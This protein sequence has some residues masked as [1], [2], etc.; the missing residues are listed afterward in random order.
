MSL[1][2][3]KALNNL[4]KVIAFS[5]AIWDLSITKFNTGYCV[6]KYVAAPYAF[7]LTS[8]N[9]CSVFKFQILKILS[10]YNYFLDIYNFIKPFPNS[11]ISLLTDSLS[12]EVGIS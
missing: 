8:E 6:L 5:G 12:R 9:K 11:K 4:S 7:G 10:S 3:I 2:E 1:L